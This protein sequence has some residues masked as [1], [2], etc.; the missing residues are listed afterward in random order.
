MPNL[1]VF[2]ISEGPLSKVE[3][4]KFIGNSFFSDG[5]LKRE[6]ATSESRWWKVL[7]SGGKYDPDL[8][9]FDKSLELGMTHFH[10][11][12]PNTSFTGNADQLPMR[13]QLQAQYLEMELLGL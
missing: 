6:I 1:E 13:H 9:N 3:S 5:R 10:L 12:K 4:I 11:N 7:T 8:L 2:E